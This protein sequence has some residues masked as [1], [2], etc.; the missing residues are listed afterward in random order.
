MILRRK[1][2]PSWHEFEESAVRLLGSPEMKEDSKNRLKIE[3]RKTYRNYQDL[4]IREAAS[5]EIASK[6]RDATT[7]IQNRKYVDGTF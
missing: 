5:E 4:C 1:Q 7:N 2:M 3:I 6:A